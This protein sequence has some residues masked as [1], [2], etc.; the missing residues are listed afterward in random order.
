MRREDPE[1]KKLVDD[2]LVG[3]MKS[4]ELERL[5]S[6]WFMSPIPPDNVNLQLPMSEMLR[7]VL[8]NPNDNGI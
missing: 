6:K 4:G 5:Y 2:T 1:F 3:M 7:D 8:R